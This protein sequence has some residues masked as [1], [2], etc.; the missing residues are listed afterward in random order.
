MFLDSME[1]KDHRALIE[2]LNGFPNGIKFSY[3]SGDSVSNENM[4]SLMQTYQCS[5]TLRFYGQHGFRIAPLPLKATDLRID[6]SHWM[7]V[8][9]VLQLEYVVAFKLENARHFTDIDFNTILK[10]IISGALPK[11]VYA[12]LE[13]KRTYNKDSIC[14]DIPMI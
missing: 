12:H 4:V 5:Q 8:A 9:N 1:N 13:L 2:W 11:M 3:I 10:R 6:H 7:T 14:W